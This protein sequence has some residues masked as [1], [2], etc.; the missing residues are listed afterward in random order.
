L[1]LIWI[2]HQQASVRRALRRLC[3]VDA[4][5]A[6]FAGPSDPQLKTSAAPTH[7]VMGICGDFEVELDFAQETLTRYPKAQWLILA[8]PDELEE[9]RR[10]FD[11]LPAEFQPWPPERN[12]LL[13]YLRSASQG[14]A[15]PLSTRIANQRLEERFLRWF[16]DL[17]LPGLERVRDPRWWSMPVLI[18][19]EPGTGRRL[20]ARALHE[21]QSEAV[22]SALLQLNCREMDLYDIESCL[23]E[24]LAQHPLRLTI[25][26]DEVDALD[27]S[28]QE[29]LVHWIE[30]APPWPCP[31]RMRWIATSDD[32]SAYAASCRLIPDLHNALAGLSLYLPPLRDDPERTVR[33]IK[34][35]MRTF[36]EEHDQSERQLTPDC[37]TRLEQDAWPGN[38]RELES[39]LFRTLAQTDKDA[40]D[41]VDLCIDGDSSNVVA[42]RPAATREAQPEPVEPGSLPPTAFLPEPSLRRLLTALIHEIGNP[43]VTL[44]TFVDL[45][46]ARFEDRN[47]RTQFSELVPPDTRRIAAVIDQL[48]RFG[49]FAAPRQEAV[50]LADSF[51]A[52][53]EQRRSAIQEKRLVVLKDFETQGIRCAGDEEQLHFAFD[54]VLRTVIELLPERGHLDLVLEHCEIPSGAPGASVVLRFRD[55]EQRLEPDLVDALSVTD[56]TLALVIAEAIVA[57]HGGTTKWKRRE[58]GE[59][60]LQFTLPRLES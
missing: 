24:G 23:R 25:W 21:L 13:A 33:F 42:P 35:T 26:L 30:D 16:G 39:L 57:A 49:A 36:C 44:Q 52:V 1:G 12:A 3:G 4:A 47:F 60:V 37:M 2:I 28:Q 11:V 34:E 15:A 5:E 7:I 8:D 51:D 40:I 14:S 45:L 54:A 38:L 46:P 17:E 27:P 55:A 56:N 18:H 22:G 43:L 20:M 53:L 10:L 29:T 48:R 59:A 31:L 19:G 58:D 32:V 50:D 6:I 9:A 41:A